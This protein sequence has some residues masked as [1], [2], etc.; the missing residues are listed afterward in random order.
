MVREISI[1]ERIY[2]G[3]EAERRPDE[4][5]GDVIERLLDPP[6]LEEFWS[7]WDEAT[8]ERARAAIDTS[9]AGSKERLERLFE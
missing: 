1:P 9:R 2:E 4:S 3:L 7:G 5:F 6:R 8:T